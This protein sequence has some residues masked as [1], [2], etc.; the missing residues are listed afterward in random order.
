MGTQEENLIDIFDMLQKYGIVLKKIWWKLLILIC[1]VTVAV[2]YR[3]KT[4]DRVTYRAY[5]IFTVS[6]QWQSNSSDVSGYYDAVTAEQLVGAFPHILTSDILYQKVENDLGYAVSGSI[7]VEV[8]EDT[9]MITISVQDTDGQRAYDTLQAVIR[10]YPEI[11]EKVVGK[12]SLNVL[13]ESGVPDPQI[14]TWNIKRS[15]LKGGFV[16]VVL[17]FLWMT[18]IVIRRKTICKEAHF[19]VYLNL[20][21]LGSLPEVQK[22][23][24]SKS[25]K[26]EKMSI[27]DPAVEKSLLEPL[28]ILRNKLEFYS[29]KQGAKTFLITSALPGEGKS[30][31]AVNLALALARTGKKVILIDGDLRHPTDRHILGLEDGKGLGEILQGKTDLSACFMESKDLGL[32][33]DQHFTFLP[34]GKSV[35]NSGKLLMRPMMK[36]IVEAAEKNYDYVLI[37]SAPVNLLSD[38]MILSK[39]SDAVIYVVRKDYAEKECILDSIEQLAHQGIPVV[40]GILN[41]V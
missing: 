10:N 25:Q 20:N 39:Y 7:Q 34:G 9:N 6:R 28:R 35:E 33:A 5:S 8:A 14:E 23:K 11:A 13:D 19:R 27:L 15:V 30:T 22:K 2:C 41:G 21:C 12:T 16:G 36:K 26:K 32:G 38:A 3:D 40:G 24:R 37:D 18:W 31:A 1:L 4:P 17:G 29:K